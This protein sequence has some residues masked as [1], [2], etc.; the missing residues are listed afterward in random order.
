MIQVDGES[1]P[2]MTFVKIV[3]DIPADRPIG[4]HYE[5]MERTR[6]HDYRWD[7]HFEDETDELNR[8]SRAILRQ[9]GYRVSTDDAGAL[10]LVGTM[11]KFSFNSYAYKTSYDQAECEM[12]WELFRAGEVKPSFITRTVGA[13]RVESGKP[14]AVSSAYKLALRGLLAEEDFV[15]AV[16]QAQP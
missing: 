3:V 11:G 12:K 8:E 7:Q 15:A 5:G 16:G 9:A 4:Y 13:G 6:Q 10:R 2:V 1:L 14:G